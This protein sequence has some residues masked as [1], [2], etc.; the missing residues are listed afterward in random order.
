MAVFLAVAAFIITQRLTMI[1]QFFVGDVVQLKK[2][3]PCGSKLWTVIRTGADVKIR[4][5]GCRRI[6]MLDREEF[7]KRATKVVHSAQVS[8]EQE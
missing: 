3:H 8:S 6:V 4:C 2:P 5:E 7:L 1:E